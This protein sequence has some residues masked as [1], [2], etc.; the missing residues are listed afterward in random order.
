MSLRIVKVGGSL[1]DWP[2]LPTALRTWLAEQ[3]PGVNVL[4]AGGGKLADVIRRAAETFGLGDEAAHWLCIEAMG[5]SA[6]LLA[7]VLDDNNS[8]L[9]SVEALRRQDGGQL[10][11]LDPREFLLRDERQLP[12]DVLPHTWSVTSDSIAARLAQVLA[13]DELVLLKSADPP[14][15][16]TLADLAACGYV[17]AYFPAAGFSGHLRAV[18]LRRHGQLAFPGCTP[19]A[20]KMAAGTRQQI[21][22][23]WRRGH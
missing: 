1:L 4:L 8:L 16:V 12:G 23:T 11:I 15:V 6:K 19:G 3:A 22:G 2:G 17:D 9:T 18:N 21:A 7:A 13:A 20:A 10:V 14:A 5:T